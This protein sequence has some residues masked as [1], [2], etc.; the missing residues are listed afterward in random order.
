MKKTPNSTTLNYQDYEKIAEIYAYIL[1]TPAIMEQLNVNKIEIGHLHFGKKQAWFNLY[2]GAV[3][4]MSDIYVKFIYE[5]ATP[6]RFKG[7]D[8]IG[9]DF[10]MEHRND[11]EKKLTDY[12]L[13][14][15][16]VI[17]NLVEDTIK[18]AISYVNQQRAKAPKE[19]I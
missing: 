14:Q 13:T 10:S 15:L 4:G 9:L 2:D 7:F 3:K 1:R 5:G 8:I 11:I 12:N 18:K 19:D 17:V 6:D 16:N